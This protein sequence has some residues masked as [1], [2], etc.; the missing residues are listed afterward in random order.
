MP[1]HLEHGMSLDLCHKKSITWK[2][3]N[4]SRN[5]ALCIGY[6]PCYPHSST[7]RFGGNP[8][9][10]T[11]T[12]S[13]SGLHTLLKL[14]FI[15][16][17]FVVDRCMLR[18]LSLLISRSLGWLGNLKSAAYQLHSIHWF[19]ICT[20]YFTF[21][22]SEEIK[23]PFNQLK[24]PRLQWTIGQTGKKTPPKHLRSISR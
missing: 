6:P 22:K 5:P 23:M 19:A 1:T 21:F 4:I 17:P 3:I 9:R 14:H 12:L 24:Q 13:V 16:I 2:T 10:S 8:V 7:V 20:L 15:A 11:D 18:L